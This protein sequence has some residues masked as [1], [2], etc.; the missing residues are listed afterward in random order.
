MTLFLTILVVAIGSI[1]ADALVRHAW[2]EAQ[3]TELYA[4][5]REVVNKVV[6][7]LLLSAISFV[8]L[9][10][11]SGWLLFLAIEE[12]DTL[13]AAGERTGLSVAR[14][15]VWAVAVVYLFIRYGWHVADAVRLLWG[16]YRKRRNA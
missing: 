7:A 3:V 6:R 15:A 9:L 10:A 16:A 13:Q 4:P 12:F 2:S 5:A 8:V 1:F 11:V 14:I